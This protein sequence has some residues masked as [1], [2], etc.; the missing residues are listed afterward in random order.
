L[1]DGRQ[2]DAEDRPVSRAGK[3]AQSEQAIG[4]RDRFSGLCPTAKALSIWLGA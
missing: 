3:L 1:Y 4:E 2:G